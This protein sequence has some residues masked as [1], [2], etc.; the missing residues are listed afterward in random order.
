MSPVPKV[1]TGTDINL[2]FQF[3]NLIND[4]KNY[5]QQMPEGTARY[6]PTR[7]TRFALNVTQVI[8]ITGSSASEFTLNVEYKML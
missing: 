3:Y 2:V 4:Q 1:G 7:V 8:M 5:A 6:L